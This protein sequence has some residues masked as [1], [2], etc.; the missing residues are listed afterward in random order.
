MRKYAVIDPVSCD[1]SPG[2]PAIR[3]CPV[4]AISHEKNGMF[5]FGPSVVDTDKC[6]GCSICLNFCPGQAISM[7]VRED[8]ELESELIRKTV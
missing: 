2:C 8:H 3:V 5:T 7:K 4:Q 6:T 1:R